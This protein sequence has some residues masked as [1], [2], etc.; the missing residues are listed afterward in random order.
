MKVRFWGVRGSI[1]SPGPQTVRYG[2]NTTCIGVTTDAGATIILD[3]GTGI[4][5]LGL[6]L[7]QDHPVECAVCI[8]HTHWDHIQGLPFFTPLFV[9]GNTVD[10]Y[11][12]FD[13]VYQKDLKS[14]LSQQMEYCYF[15]VRELELKA[16]VRYHTIREGVSVEYADATITNVM[17]NH[18]VMTYGYRI[19]C[20]GKSV[21]FT[22]DHEPPYNI[23]NED[24]TFYG[25]YEQLIDDKVENIC[26]AASNVDLLIADAQYT[27]PE[28]V[29]RRGWGHGT[30]ASSLSMARRAQAKAVCFTHHDPTRTDDQL[31]TIAQ[32]LAAQPR[33]NDPDLYIAHEGLEIDLG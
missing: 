23:Y 10:V 31:D 17:M 13:P 18:P 19:D 7:M 21:F 5:P 20:N 28:M 33:P 22:G 12:A 27:E 4:R 14:I 1:A 11:G 2:G 6:L 3:G 8:T 26:K 15:P 16:D 9:P 30:F 25:E 29:N 24:D 32:K